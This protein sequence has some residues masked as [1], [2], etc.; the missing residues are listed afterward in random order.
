MPG[1]ALNKGADDWVPA[2]PMC[3]SFL[4]YKTNTSLD[5]CHN[6]LLGVDY[7][8]EDNSRGQGILES[9]SSGK[10]TVICKDKKYKEYKN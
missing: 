9:Q 3:L 5:D 10:G 6:V 1:Y 8:L 7:L 2:S 4:I